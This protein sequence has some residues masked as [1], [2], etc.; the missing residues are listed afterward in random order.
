MMA[1]TADHDTA[2][3]L[4]KSPAFPLRYIS[5]M[6]ERAGNSPAPSPLQGS[7]LLAF[8]PGDQPETIQLSFR[9][10]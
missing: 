7:A 8:L 5:K 9:S 1:E 3:E 10:L 6:V 2:T 4:S